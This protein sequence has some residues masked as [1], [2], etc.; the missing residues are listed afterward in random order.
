MG[1]L[2]LMMMMM[3][4]TAMA[5]LCDGAVYKVGD[6]AGWTT[7][8]NVDYKQWSATKTFQLGDTILFQYS[9]QFHNVMHVTHAEFRACNTTSPKATYTTGNDSI[10]LTNRGH[11]YFFCGVPGHCQAGQ[12]VD[13]NVL[14]KPVSAQTPSPSAVPTPGIQGPSPNNGHLPRALKGSFAKL[15]LLTVV[16]AVCC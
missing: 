1:A 15:G 9:A 13:I 8:G 12:K 5:K 4:A 2:M 3:M 7:I 10:T 16:L 11:H 6:T 14:R